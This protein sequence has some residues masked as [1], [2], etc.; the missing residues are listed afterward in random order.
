MIFQPSFLIYAFQVLAV[1][2]NL[3]QIIPKY[4][5]QRIHLSISKTKHFLSIVL[6]V[7]YYYCYLSFVS[8]VW[9]PQWWGRGW[10]WER[11]EASGIPS[12]LGH[13]FFCSSVF[14]Q[15][16]HGENLRL[17]L[18]VQFMLEHWI[19]GFHLCQGLEFGERAGLYRV[20]VFCTAGLLAGFWASPR[21][22]VIAPGKLRECQCC[23]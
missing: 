11:G 7:F 9:G 18:E 15:G 14:S 1:S 12:L 8:Y 3:K 23:L 4:N 2:F 20:P 6:K 13:G 10:R 21:V 5:V 17:F 22:P 16:S 19:L